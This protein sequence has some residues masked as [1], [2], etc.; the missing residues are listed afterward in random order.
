MVGLSLHKLCNI[1]CL[2]AL[3]SAPPSFALELVSHPLLLLSLHEGM[4]IFSPHSTELASHD[5][6][7]TAYE[8]PDVFLCCVP[9][10]Q[11]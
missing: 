9:D 5:G 1:S 7:L 11:L 10:V 4:A 3:L 8:P 2:P 6:M